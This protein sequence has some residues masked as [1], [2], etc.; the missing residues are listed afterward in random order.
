MKNKFTLSF[1]LSLLA[2]ALSCTAVFLFKKQEKKIAFVLI[3]DLFNEFELKKEMETSYTKAK[4]ARKRIIDSLEVDLSVLAG[5]LQS[6]Q[7]KQEDK[8]LFDRRRHEYE[9][10]RKLF[11]EDNLYMSK[12]FDEQ[13]IKQL[14]QYVS[15]FGKANQYDIIYGNTSNGSIMYGTDALNITKEVITFINNKYRGVK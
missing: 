7:V 15:D 8:E 10:K 13:I 6:K 4:N 11:D 9:Q 14:N 3:T 12:Q 1:Y 5:R 2:L